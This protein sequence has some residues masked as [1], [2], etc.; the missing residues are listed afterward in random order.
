VKLLALAL[1]LVVPLAQ[2]QMYKCKD[3]RG[4]WQFSDKPLPG[5]IDKPVVVAP[6]PPQQ[7]AP[8][9]AKK[10]TRTAAGPVRPAAKKP[11]PTEHEKAMYASDC[12][13]NKEQLEWMLGPRGQAIENRET[14]VAQ[15]RQA[16]QGCPP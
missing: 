4:R 2:A 14:R 12:R 5:C 13:A 9:P 6:P 7:A 16:I 3:E 15:L 11:P 10:G 8:P 1:L